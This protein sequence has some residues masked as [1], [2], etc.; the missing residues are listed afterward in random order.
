MNGHPEVVVDLWNR[1]RVNKDTPK[2]NK[3]APKLNKDE[4]SS[5]HALR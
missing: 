4:A 5:E 1:T 3:D 2:R